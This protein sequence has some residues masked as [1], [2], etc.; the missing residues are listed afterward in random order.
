[1]SVRLIVEGGGDGKDQRAECRRGFRNLLEK[2]GLVGRMPRIVAGGGRAETFRDF[3]CALAEQSG[4][5][6][7]LVDSE[8]PVTV[9][10][11]WQ[12]LEHSDG[13]QHPSDTT[14]DHCHL[15]VQSMEAWLLADR[16]RLSEFFGKGFREGA[17]PTRTDVENVDKT[18]AVQALESA[19]RDCAA[20]YRKGANSFHALAAIDPAAVRASSPWAER[21]FAAIERLCR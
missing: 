19:T 6:V 21:F 8:G 4:M 15:M 11:P 10:S 5:P 7:L 16:R 2:A 3:R 12:H 13:W 17:L 14:D 9:A 18:H 20:G 1:V